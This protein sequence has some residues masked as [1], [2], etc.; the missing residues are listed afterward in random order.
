MAD[1][2]YCRPERCTR[3][4]NSGCQLNYVHAPRGIAVTVSDQSLGCKDYDPRWLIV[5]NTPAEAAEKFAELRQK[6][7]LLSV[8]EA[9]E[10]TEI[11]GLTVDE[12]VSVYRDILI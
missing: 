10:H 4:A 5:A 6:H 12:I 8:K 3:C 11:S 2:V 1:K 9:L 7:Q